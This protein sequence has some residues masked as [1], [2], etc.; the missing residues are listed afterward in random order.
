M[1]KKLSLTNAIV[2]LMNWSNVFSDLWYDEV[3]WAVISC[4]SNGMGWGFANSISFSGIGSSFGSC[5]SGRI[6][7]D[8]FYPFLV[9][10]IVV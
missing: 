1:V 6:S 5:I 4:S 8:C 9:V 3:L 7:S 2:W 10:L